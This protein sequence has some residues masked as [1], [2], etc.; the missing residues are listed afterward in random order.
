MNSTT[1]HIYRKKSKKKQ[2]SIHAS[3]FVLCDEGSASS[4]QE[5]KLLLRTRQFAVAPS[6]N[7]LLG[8]GW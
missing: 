2:L 1:A 5:R 3:T 4:E 7:D 8:S 6:M